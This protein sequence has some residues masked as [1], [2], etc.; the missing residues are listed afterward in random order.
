MHVYNSYLHVFELFPIH[1]RF[2]SDDLFVRT[3]LIQFRDVILIYIYVYLYL[4]AFKSIF[5]Y[6][7]FSIIYYLLD[8]RNIKAKQFLL[9]ASRSRKETA[10]MANLFLLLL[11]LVGTLSLQLITSSQAKRHFSHKRGHIL[12]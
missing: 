3:Y 11:L 4:F 6:N 5:K 7:F 1:S 12:S 2:G 9:T 8:F 10:I